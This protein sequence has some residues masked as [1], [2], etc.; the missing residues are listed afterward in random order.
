MVINHIT[1]TSNISIL[2]SKFFPI[3]NKEFTKV[4]VYNKEQLTKYFN[5][6]FNYLVN[7]EYKI[8]KEKSDDSFIIEKIKKIAILNEHSEKNYR[9]LSS[10]ENLLKI[11]RKSVLF[12]IIIEIYFILRFLKEIDDN[13]QTV[14]NISFLGVYHTKN[15]QY[16]FTHIL[17]LYEVV[18]Y[19]DTDPNRCIHIKENIDMESLIQEQHSEFKFIKKFDGKK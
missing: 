15:I 6:Y 18:K 5:E 16:F 1:E 14:L 10:D 2:F 7:N 13:R 4:Q 9:N 11:A 8:I 12:H 19:Y 17:K 3:I